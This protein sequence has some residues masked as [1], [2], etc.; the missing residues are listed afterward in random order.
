MRKN[1]A[2]IL[3][4]LFAGAIAF[5]Q[6]TL[7]TKGGSVN[8]KSLALLNTVSNIYKSSTGTQIELKITLLDNKTGKSGTTTGTLKT[9]G[10]KFN[11]TTNFA[12]MVFDG[13]TLNVFD[14]QNKELQISTPSSDEVSS[15]DPT[16]IIS[17]FKEGYKISEPEYSGDIAVVRLYP[18]DRASDVSMIMIS[19]N[20][21]TNTPTTIKSCGK[22][23]VD[24]I[25]EIIKIDVNQKFPES[26]FEL[27]IDKYK[28]VQIIDLR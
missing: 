1:L 27:N 11:L 7:G 4:T 19:I 17:M 25:V 13:K 3:L 28:N 23:G 20:T 16:A 10:S 15:I 9:A 26:T 6:N 12:L 2:L 22:N 24:N 18:E 8:E 5:A 21:K 14:K